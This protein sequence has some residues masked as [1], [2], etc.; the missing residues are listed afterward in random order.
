MKEISYIHSEAYPAGE[1]KHGPLA[2][3]DPHMCSVLI[4]PDDAAYQSNMSTLAEIKARSGRLC[5]I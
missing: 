1:L 3:I 4:A 5:V 2:L